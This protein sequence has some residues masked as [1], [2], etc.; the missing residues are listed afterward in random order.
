M[1]LIS[2]TQVDR[3]DGLASQECAGNNK[4]RLWLGGVQTEGRSWDLRLEAGV[5]RLEAWDVRPVQPD[6]YGPRWNHV[7]LERSLS[8]LQ[9]P[10]PTSHAPGP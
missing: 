7:A 9:A 5:L 10:C 8:G 6:P 3:R 4:M 1:P 2:R